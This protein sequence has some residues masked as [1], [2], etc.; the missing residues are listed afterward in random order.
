MGTDA[1]V[2]DSL[3]S[4]LRERL[5]EEE[6]DAQLAQHC[7]PAPWTV[8]H[9]DRYANTAVIRY[10]KADPIGQ[11]PE[12]GARAEYDDSPAIHIARWDPARVLAECAA[13]RAIL[14]LAEMAYAAER[15]PDP[16]QTGLV[17]GW[18]EFAISAV[19]RLAQ[20]YAD[21]DDFRDEWRET[22]S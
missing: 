6:A 2:T 11:C 20:P 8:A 3:I 14:G 16:H 15:P 5:A 7:A 21:R 10:A 13:K 18:R 17:N 12:C 1:T 4:Y 22:P 9:G 19:R